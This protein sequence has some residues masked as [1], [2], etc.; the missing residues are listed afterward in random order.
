MDKIIKD[1]LLSCAMLTLAYFGSYF[2]IERASSINSSGLVFMV[3]V[4]FI[5][6]YT[7]GYLYGILASMASVLLINY[8][9]MY[10]YKTFNITIDGYPIA[11]FSM[12]LC[13]VLVSTITTKMKMQMAQNEKLF[14]ERA[15]I[16]LETEKE[17]MRS[18]LLRAISHDLRTPLTGIYGASSTI[19][20]NQENITNAEMVQFANNIMNDTQG[21]INMVENL[22]SVTK[23][24]EEGAKI[25]KSNE[26][27]EEVVTEA[28]LKIKKSFPNCKLN[29][30]LSDEIML[31]PMDSLLIRQVMFNL[32]ENAIKH[33]GNDEELDISV[34]REEYI[35]IF[36]VR[37][38][39]KGLPF[40]NI[41]LLIENVIMNNAAASDATRGSGLGL[42]VC[43]SII[44][45][46]GGFLEAQNAKGGGSIFRFGLEMKEMLN[47]D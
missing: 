6:R 13:S 31:V 10:P 26:V 21:L 34:Y 24:N 47:Y 37:D 2:F 40:E 4:V 22:L 19:I 35:A 41:D 44:R 15:E 36:E 33:A 28:I 8:A 14:A 3:A 18:N 11:V 12:I 1:I 23:V 38:H 30:N 46:H 9:F 45:A 27:F 16:R 39:G 32:I 25:I 17:R 43:K 20:E 5:A 42:S 7:N 29:L